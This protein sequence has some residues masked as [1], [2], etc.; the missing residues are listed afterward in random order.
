VLLLA[1][2]SILHPINSEALAVLVPLPPKVA[3]D[4]AQCLRR[5]LYSSTLGSPSSPWVGSSLLSASVQLSPL[6][7]S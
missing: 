1:P 2:T 6:L 5:A 4:K 7:F 3:L